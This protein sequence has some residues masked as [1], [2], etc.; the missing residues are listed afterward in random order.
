M[1][2]TA[3]NRIWVLATAAFIALGWMVSVSRAA[4]SK[5]KPEITVG[6][7]RKLVYLSSPRGD[8]IPDYSYCGYRLGE[9]AIPDAPVKIVVAPADGDSTQRIQSAIDHVSAMPLGPDGIRGAVLLKKG[10]YEVAGALHITASGVVL[11][12]SGAGDDGTLL[13]ATGPDRRTLIQVQG[14]DDRKVA[15]TQPIS[16]AYI[17]TNAKKLTLPTGQAPHPGDTVLVRRPSTAAWIK[18]IDMDDVGGG[19]GL[20]WKEG[21][22][23]LVWD[24]TVAAVD[25]ESVTLDAPLTTAIDAD[26]GRGSVGT[27]SWPGRINQVGVENLRCESAISSD[28]PKD[29]DHAW[30]AISLNAVRDAWVRQVTAVHFAGCMVALWDGCSRVTVEDCISKAPVSEVAGWRRHTFYTAGQQTL[31]QRCWSENGR[32]DFG[33]GFCAAGPNAFVQCEAYGSVDDS[34]PI[35]SLASGALFDN[36]RIEGNGL[37]LANRTYKDQFSGWSATDS[38]L[39]Q[40]TAA[41]ITCDAPP[42][43][44][45]WAYGCWGQYSGNGT[46]YSSDSFVKPTS[47]YYGQ[48]ADR[49]GPDAARRADLMERSTTEAT[50][51]SQEETDTYIAASRQPAPLLV[52]WIE[53]AARRRPIPVSPGDAPNI[54]DLRKD[55]NASAKPLAKR[56]IEI[57]NGWICCDGQVISGDQRDITWWNGGVRPFDVSSAAMREPNVT[58]FVPGRVGPGLTDDLDQLTDTLLATGYAALAHHYGLWYDTR[59]ADH[60]RVRRMNGDVWPPFYELPFARSGTG[61]A[62]DGLSKYDLTKY[63][64]WYW[65]RLKQFADLGEQ[66]GVLLFQQHYFQHNVLEAGAHWASSPWRSANNINDTGFPEPP[67]YAGDKRI[68]MAEQFYDASHPT[69]GPLHRAF[70]RQNL[71]NSANNTNVVHMTSAEFTG[72]LPFTQFW[73]D[74]IREWEQEKGKQATVAISAPKDV[75]DGIL[76]NP[77][78]AKTVNVVDIRY[79]WYQPD[80]RAYA[81]PGGGNLSP[82]QW[83]RAMHPK[84]PSFPQIVRAVREYRERYPDKAV[85]FSVDVPQN[86]GWAILIGGGSLGGV[87]LDP[88]LAKAIANTRPVD[89][90]GKPQ[91]QWAL[92]EPGA[93]YVVYR[94]GNAATRLDLTG[95][96]GEFVVRPVDPRSGQVGDVV[97]TVS[98]GGTVQIGEKA[99]GARVLWLSRPAS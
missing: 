47:L 6:P 73:V 57:R 3:S 39:W 21:T 83:Q 82:R 86:M 58:R 64:P 52:N 32:H 70:I 84:G 80:G 12:G 97:E 16:D 60:E 55:D 38:M 65:N 89:L 1:R 8:R 88:G 81:P 22:R 29:E 23:D 75:Q 92:A 45:N 48:L 19:I 68:F 34:G 78:R 35:D 66:K 74:V 91:D 67:P 94:S 27:Y 2:S 93:N 11:R 41:L 43:I 59:D 13:V 18:S 87:R 63:N 17:P 33:V 15:T 49:L 50:A 14:K 69:R 4:A 40:C 56:T 85:L 44:R 62:W 5:E 99:A 25:G 46:F 20:G 24:R 79:W 31:F 95:Q 28:K 7:D 61:L 96:S 10:R 51:P 9:A 90:P 71:D 77:E 36:V 98:G 30:F 53:G 72:P 42:S 54:D 26:L 76:A 37:S